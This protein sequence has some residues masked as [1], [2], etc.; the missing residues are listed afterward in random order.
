MNIRFITLVPIMW[1]LLP[2]WLYAI[3]QS[4]N[5]ILASD[6][7]AVW[8]PLV[9]EAMNDWPYLDSPLRAKN[10]DDEQMQ[11]EF[12]AVAT[13]LILKLVGTEGSLVKQPYEQFRSSLLILRDFREKLRSK[14][15]Y[16]NLVLFDIFRRFDG[17][18]RVKRALAN[19]SE[20]SLLIG[21]WNIPE[22]N[23]YA[24]EFCFAALQREATIRSVDVSGEE[25]RAAADKVGW[26]AKNAEH[27]RARPGLQLLIMMERLRSEFAGNEKELETW[28]KF[29]STALHGSP[30]QLLSNRRPVG[31]LMQ[32]ALTWTI[33]DLQIPLALEI[34]N[35]NESASTFT[36]L[37]WGIVVESMRDLERSKYGSGKD[38]Y[39]GAAS[40]SSAMEFLVVLQRDDGISRVLND[41]GTTSWELL[42]SPS[43]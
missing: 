21:D 32:I 40:L 28:G 42:K 33:L 4:W 38:P 19:P 14:P 43:P 11:S 31:V 41:E 39:K 23:D 17:A 18:I 29:D 8:L 16:G 12:R 26:G 37:K 1:L 10:T 27:S 20:R 3:P 7:P 6:D 15:S 30:S 24:T 13:R 9:A 5:E 36:E 34:L 35:R 22:W 25:L 2:S